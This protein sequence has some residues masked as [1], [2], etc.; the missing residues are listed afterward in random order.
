M[1]SKPKSHILWEDQSHERLYSIECRC[2]PCK[3][4]IIEGL[5]KQLGIKEFELIQAL[6]FSNNYQ[7]R[8]NWFDEIEAAL[9]KLAGP[10][11][12]TIYKALLI[13]AKK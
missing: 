1:K 12:K 10:H 4:H 7:L 3:S 11:G 9:H 5:A 2:G 8:F 6:G 13:R